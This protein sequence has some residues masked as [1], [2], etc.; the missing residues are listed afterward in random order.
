MELLNFIHLEN[1]AVLYQIC[2]FLIFLSH[3]YTSVPSV[4]VRK[5]PRDFLIR[6]AIR[7]CGYQR[8]LREYFWKEAQHFTVPVCW[9][10]SLYYL[11]CLLS[12]L[13]PLGCPGGAPPL[14][15]P[16]WFLLISYFSAQW[17]QTREG[18]KMTASFSFCPEAKPGASIFDF[19]FCKIWTEIFLS[20][21]I[22]S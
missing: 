20:S 4:F 15:Q 2:A 8:E 6:S 10:M 3:G 14:C 11:W 22:D 12:F 5:M 17:T 13:N 19:I 18:Q 21:F 9:S 1:R 7:L 16:T